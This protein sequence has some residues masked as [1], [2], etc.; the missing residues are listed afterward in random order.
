[1]R[2]INRFKHS[3]RKCWRALFHTFWFIPGIVSLGGPSLA[4]CFLAFDKSTKG[5]LAAPYLFHGSALA[6]STLLS[7]IA[8]SLITVAGLA[9][10]ITIVALQLVF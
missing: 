8:G 7:T 3:I 9:F 10:S 1:M 2:I 5:I 6:A 4:F